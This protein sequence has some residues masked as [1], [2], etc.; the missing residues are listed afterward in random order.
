M[1]KNDTYNLQSSFGKFVRDGETRKMNGVVESR[2][3]HYR[4]LVRNIANDSLRSAYPITYKILNK[5]EWDKLIDDFMINHNSHQPQVWRYPYELIKYFEKSNYHLEILKKE[6][7]LDLLNFEWVEMEVHGMIDVEI[8]IFIK[9]I[10]LDKKL[11]I[12]PYA[13]LQHYEYPVFQKQ[14]N[15]LEEK[16]GNYFVICWRKIS[17][18]EVSYIELNP[19]FAII[20]EYLKSGVPIKELSENL[21][22][23]YNLDFQRN[24]DFNNFINNMLEK[25]IILGN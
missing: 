1:L 19:L 17:N 21:K 24:A 10:S 15:N 9:E 7:L 12:N 6:Y 23:D 13:I 8:P 22:N 4:R 11:I 2:L 20:F 5:S 16:K 14:N 25:E 18:L 3:H